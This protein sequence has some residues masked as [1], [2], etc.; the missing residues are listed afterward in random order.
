MSKLGIKGKL[1]RSSKPT[2]LSGDI[3]SLSEYDKML[4][5]ATALGADQNEFYFRYN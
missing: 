5:V 4:W 2:H 3:K 1:N